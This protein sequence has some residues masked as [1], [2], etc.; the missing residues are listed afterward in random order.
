[1]DKK[2]Q[3]EFES[4]KSHEAAH[5]DPVG[6]AY[7][8]GLY[9]RFSLAE[10]RD[11]EVLRD[12]LLSALLEYRTQYDLQREL[13]NERVAAIRTNFPEVANDAESLFAASDFKKLEQLLVQQEQAQHK[14]SKL[15]GLRSLVN[16]INQ[17]SEK[18]T[19]PV[20]Q[21]TSFE[22]LLD[23]QEQRMLDLDGST[24]SAMKEGGGEQLELQSMRF[25]RESTKHAHIDSVLER[26][27]DE[28]PTNPG[29]HNPHMLSVKTLTRMRDISP[30]YLRRL[31]GYLETLMWLEK[32]SSK[33]INK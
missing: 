2:V 27:I 23:E 26:A 7:L 11:N 22:D 5:V 24:S 17:Q 30:A 10:N 3:A 32:N 29:P 4:L 16:D 33:L 31:G 21:K 25:F 18:A 9:S 19:E 8:Q 6:F 15:H 28:C 14:I 1:M 20:E 13:A 12:K